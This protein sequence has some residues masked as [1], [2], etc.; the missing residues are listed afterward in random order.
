MKLSHLFP[1]IFPIVFVFCNKPADHKNDIVKVGN[2]IYN[3]DQYDAFS[4][5]YRFYPSKMNDYFPG[6][7]STISFMVE[8]DAIY[9]KA[10]WDFKIRRSLKNL[11]WK[12]KARYFPAQLYI[13]ENLS[14]N[15]GTTDKQI[16][17]YYSAHKD[18]FKVTR[19]DST[20]KKD[21]TF[22]SPVSEV[23]ENIVD[24][25]FLQKNSPDSVFLKLYGDS[26]PNKEVLN[27]NWLNF[28]KSNVPQF[29]MKKFYKET[30][31]TAY[32]DSVEKIFG[33]GKV[34]TQQDMDVILSWVPADRRSYYENPQG[35]KELVEWLLKWKL[36]SEAA[37]KS[38]FTY[39][40]QVSNIMKWALKLEVAQLYLNQKI[41]PAAEK[42][43][44][45]VDSSMVAYEFYDD[46]GNTDVAPDSQNISSRINTAHTAMVSNVIDSMI[47]Q[48]R[49]AK[50][51]KF[52]Q[53]DVTDDK[54]V[55]PATLLKQADTFR[56][57]GSTDAAEKMYNILSTNFFFSN[58][59]KKAT[60][61]LAKIQTE[62]Q[63][64]YQA[65]KTY[66]KLLTTGQ[67]AQRCN[68]FFMI[69]F[70]YD[71]NLDKPELAELNY[72]WVL[73]NEPGCE[74]AD[75]AEFMMLHLG[76]PMTSV[77]DL[78]SEAQRQGR[79]VEQAQAN[80]ENISTDTK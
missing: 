37:K 51:V 1:V 61:E 40:Q 33:K 53:N 23:K 39:S 35:K 63:L 62:K 18:L 44:P 80:A 59:G 28:V 47:Y 9:N 69:G 71:E 30:Y 60:A 75:D 42:A 65:I 36:F 50:G 48:L 29:F 21:T 20:G 14:T 7:R 2:R 57:S 4:K 46:Y 79:K 74:L 55:D 43:C 45:P 8:T 19:K 54:T 3:N 67:S 27:K 49:K 34:I 26:I 17:Q 68:T 70:I 6:S 24:S 52:L 58:E 13:T 32:P 64:Y 22:Y 12:W 73:K 78:Q 10:K 66:R 76:E 25:I 41:V 31:G 77:E 38:G 5:V 72:K 56:D 15:L 16:E 11:D